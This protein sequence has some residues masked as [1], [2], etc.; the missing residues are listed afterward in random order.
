MELHGL[1]QQ[2]HPHHHHAHAHHQGQ[3]QAYDHRL[4]AAQ[5]YTSLPI[6]YAS[7]SYIGIPHNHNHQQQQGQGGIYD[8]PFSHPQNAQQQEQAYLR[9]QGYQNQ[10]PTSAPQQQKWKR[11][12]NVWED[13]CDCT[14]GRWMGK[15]AP[16]PATRAVSANPDADPGGGERADGEALTRAIQAKPA[17][18]DNSNSDAVAAGERTRDTSAERENAARGRGVNGGVNGSGNGGGEDPKKR[19]ECHIGECRK[20]F[21][22]KTHLEIHIRAHTGAKPYTCTYPTCTHAFSQLGNLKTHLRR[23]TGERPFACPTC[24]KSSAQRGIVRAHAAVHDAGGAAK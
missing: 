24:G 18:G 2:S 13:D 12:V 16:T 8:F 11:S 14:S 4:P 5:P 21:F 19:Y 15:T 17:G 22:Q 1:L 3:G 9:R 10:M 20:A 23:H 7:S 6:S